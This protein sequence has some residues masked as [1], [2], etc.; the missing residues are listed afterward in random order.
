MVS[1]ELALIRELIAVQESYRLLSLVERRLQY[2][3]AEVVF[4]QAARPIG[5]RIVAGGCQAEWIG[6]SRVASKPVLVYLHGGA[7]TLGS[8]RSH[9]HLAVAIGD[10]AGTSILSLDYRLAPEHPFP[11]AVE[12]SVAAYLWLLE[13]GVDPLEVVLAGDSAGGGLVIA[14]MLSLVRTG[15]KMPAAGVC[16]SPWV[17]LTCAGD[18][19]VTN[20][21]RD[22]ILR[23][24]ELQYMAD[25]YV[26]SEDPRNPL[27]SPIF[28]NLH[29]LPP[30]LIQV[31]SDEILLDDA[32]GLARA[33]RAAGVGITLEE[34]SD[35]IHVWHW[36]F[37]ILKEGRQ[38]IDAIG[39]FIRS[40]VTG[41]K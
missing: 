12:D 24:Q 13:A 25:M 29:G 34:W 33:A 4:A 32:R 27:A 6:H 19:H 8:P 9:R 23:T 36:Y 11:A 18:S 39:Q 10:S 40:R 3:R 21:G 28:A 17:D 7:Y 2:D 37:A 5:E 26:G 20:A 22:P 14:T 31:G 16:I 41:T 35:M 15:T 30:L 1:S 38:A